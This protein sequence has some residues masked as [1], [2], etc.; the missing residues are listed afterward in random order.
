MTQRTKLI[1]LKNRNGKS[2]FKCNY[3]YYPAFNYFEEADTI[4]EY[5]N[6]QTRR[7]NNTNSWD[8]DLPF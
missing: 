7:Y 6:N 2:Y 3:K 5:T 8:T 1:G 4:P